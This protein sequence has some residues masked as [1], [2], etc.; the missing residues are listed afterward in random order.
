MV[1]ISLHSKVKVASVYKFLNYVISVYRFS[2]CK[3]ESAT[4]IKAQIFISLHAYE[5]WGWGVYCFQLVRHSDIISAR[6]GID[7]VRL[8][9]KCICTDVD[10]I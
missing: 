7:G 3:Q 10:Q 1:L 8:N 4:K 9:F 6:E 5:V 2:S